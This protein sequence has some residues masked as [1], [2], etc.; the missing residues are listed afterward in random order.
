MKI[1]ILQ[2][3]HIPRELENKYPNYSQQFITML[4]GNGFEFINYDILNEKLP[5]SPSIADGWLITG[6]KYGVYEDHSWIKPLE[7]FIKNSY[8][9]NI[10]MVGICFGIK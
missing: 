8:N 2:T 10:P 3:G 5:V 4:Q 1:G 9:D 7:N 6:S